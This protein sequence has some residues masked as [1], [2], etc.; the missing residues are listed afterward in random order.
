MVI[1]LD[2][3]N[4]IYFIIFKQLFT[5]VRYILQYHK[6]DFQTNKTMK[7]FYKN[8]FYLIIN[9]SFVIHKRITD[10]IFLYWRNTLSLLGKAKLETIK[11]VI[12]VQSPNPML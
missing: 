7:I 1:Y 2:F 6:I 12:F 9:V 10:I 4:Q 11:G 5:L 3:I 8:I